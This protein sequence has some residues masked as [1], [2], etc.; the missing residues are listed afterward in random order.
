MN[1]S[2]Q[3]CADTGR[4]LPAVNIIIL[5]GVMF[6]SVNL[7]AEK[8]GAANGVDVHVRTVLG[9]GAKSRSSVSVDDRINDISSQ[10]KKLQYQRYSL[11]SA[12]EGFVEVAHKKV[13]GLSNGHTL[14]LRPLYIEGSRV[15]MWLKWQDD[16]GM[17]L[18]DTRMHF[19]CGEAFL[20]GTEKSDDSGVIL[21]IDVQPAARHSRGRKA[22]GRK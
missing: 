17:D 14:S 19:T 5:L 9:A 1:V 18:L 3:G 22:A 2:G 11:I 8:N 12:R 20:T 16:Q 13:F 15:G 21:A 10:L 7:Y 4:N 6:F